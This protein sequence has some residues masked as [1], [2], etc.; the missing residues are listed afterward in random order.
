MIEKCKD[1]CKDIKTL[2]T[3]TGFHNDLVQT[4]CNY[5]RKPYKIDQMNK[6]A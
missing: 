1:K 2:L 5:L 3:K 4:V 6:P